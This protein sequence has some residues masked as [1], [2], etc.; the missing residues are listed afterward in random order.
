MDIAENRA[1]LVQAMK[2]NIL[3]LLESP[4][5]AGLGRNCETQ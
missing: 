2:R 4:P 5:A 1:N 3:F